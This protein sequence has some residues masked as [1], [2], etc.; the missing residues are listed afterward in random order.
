M[1]EIRLIGRKKR[2]KEKN[3]KKK[4]WKRLEREKLGGGECRCS[5]KKDARITTVMSGL[6]GHALAPEPRLWTRLQ[7]HCPW[8]SLSLPSLPL[9]IS[10]QAGGRAGVPRKAGGSPPTPRTNPLFHAP[11]PL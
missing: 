8:L 3:G 11:Q 9:S 7:E 1:G 4:N 2:G 10:S 6:S 5:S